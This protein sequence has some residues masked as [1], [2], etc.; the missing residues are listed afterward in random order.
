MTPSSV[1]SGS[2]IAKQ[3]PQ[4]TTSHSA[5]AAAYRVTRPFK[6]PARASFRHCS[7]RGRLAIFKIHT[8]HSHAQTHTTSHTLTRPALTCRQTSISLLCFKHCG[9][10][11]YKFCVRCFKHCGSSVYK[12][13]ICL[14]PAGR[15]Q[16]SQ[17]LST[18]VTIESSKRTPPL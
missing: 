16:H 1:V 2:S 5:A 14:S 12:F 10:S 3:Q 18:L 9:S 6:Q 8:Q 11:A 13:C 7:A 4:A 17:F 15:P